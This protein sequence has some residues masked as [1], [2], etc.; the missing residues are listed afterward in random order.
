MSAWTLESIWVKNDSYS[1]IIMKFTRFLE[2]LSEISVIIDLDFRNW[3]N[4][5]VQKTDKRQKF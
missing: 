4:E 3:E 5:Q 2:E 1:Q